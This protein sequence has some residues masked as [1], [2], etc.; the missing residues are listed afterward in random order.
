MFDPNKPYSPPKLKALGCIHLSADF[1]PVAKHSISMV[2]DTRL[3][4]DALVT[5]EV[6]F[7]P[8]LCLVFDASEQLSEDPWFHAAVNE[9]HNDHMRR[10]WT[11]ADGLKRPHLFGFSE[12]V[13]LMIRVESGVVASIM[14]LNSVVRSA[15]LKIRPTL[16][17]W[18]SCVHVCGTLKPL[19]RY[20]KRYSYSRYHVRKT[21]QRRNAGVVPGRFV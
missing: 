14:S 21:S 10:Y 17:K 12:E 7:P 13:T 8:H 5:L 1:I 18:A 2:V 16:P 11:R 20:L 15:L 6:E 4:W 9:P 3:G 19:N